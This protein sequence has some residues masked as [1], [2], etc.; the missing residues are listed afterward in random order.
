MKRRTVRALTIVFA[1]VAVTFLLTALGPQ[2]LAQ[3]GCA[4][5]RALGHGVLPTNH[6]LSDTDTW[7]GDVWGTLGSDF[8]TGTFTG[9]D[10]DIAAHGTKEISNSGT[11]GHYTFSFGNGDSFVMEVAH[12]VFNF[13][14]GK[15][16]FGEYKGHATIVSGTGKFA[17]AS[18]SIDW[19][20]PFVV[21]TPDE[22]LTF[23][24]RFNPTIT[25]T[26]CGI[27]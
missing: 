25:G 26:I 24:G 3:Q 8:L 1:F 14:P 13:P 15:A 2:I 18:G 9:N 21:W 17:T 19:G 10:G 23:S 4:S 22:G 12:A 16:G 5:L 27:Q 6:Q 20:G 7:G 11:N